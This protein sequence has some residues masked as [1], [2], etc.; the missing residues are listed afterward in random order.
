LKNEIREFE[1]L[2]KQASGTG[3]PSDRILIAVWSPLDVIGP[4]RR[5]ARRTRVQ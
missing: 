2:L 5:I 3:L 4:F 1:K